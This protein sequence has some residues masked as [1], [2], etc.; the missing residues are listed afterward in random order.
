M[1]VRRTAVFLLVLTAACLR[2]QTGQFTWQSETPLLD[3]SCTAAASGRI[4]FGTAGGL[5]IFDPRD[6]SFSE[7]TNTDGLSGSDV[8][9]LAPSQ[10]GVRAGYDNGMIDRISPAG[11]V[12]DRIGDFAGYR[13]NRIAVTGDSLWVAHD[14]GISLYILSKSE[15]KETYRQLGPS[16]NRDQPVVDILISGGVIWAATAEGLCRAPLSSINLLDPGAWTR[17]TTADGLPGNAVRTLAMHSGVLYAATSGGV[18]RYDSAFTTVLNAGIEALLSDSDG[19]YAGGAGCLYRSVQGGSFAAVPGCSGHITAL[20][21][22]TGTLYAGTTSGILILAGS[23]FSSLQPDCIGGTLI[24][25][26]SPDPENG[27]WVTT[28]DNGFYLYRNGSWSAFR[29]A[30]LAG[31]RSR[32]QYTAFTDSRNRTWIGSWGGG[33]TQI[34]GDGSISFFHPDSGYLSGI[35]NDA[36][37][38]VISD[39]AEDGTGTVWFLNYYAAS[40]RPLA[41]VTPEGTWVYF[42]QNEGLTSP[43]VSAL[44]IDEFGR[45]YIGTRTSGL[46]IFDDSGTPEDKSDD[47]PVDRLT[48]SSGLLSDEITDLAV[49]P[50]GTVW[51]GTPLGLNYLYGGQVQQVYGLPSTAVTALVI[52]PA[53]NIWAGSRNGLNLFTASE[54]RWNL[55]TKSDSYLLDDEI[56]ALSMDYAA[57][58]LY[59]G[60]NRGISLLKT[61]YTLPAE[62]PEQLKTYPNPFRPDEDDALLIDGLTEGVSVDIMTAGGYLVR[63]FEKETVYGRQ[64]WW[65]GRTSRGAPAA[66]GVYVIV[67]VNENGSI[68]RGKCVLIR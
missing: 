4:W 60:T 7:I 28:R 54:Y 16:M 46:F 6:D 56:T 5:L 12:S 22:E 15:V 27:L 67:A 40:A 23:V 2:G 10:D 18:C 49:G 41:A 32:D 11:S 47:L 63:R 24:S 43:F 45:K 62:R 58:I 1:K 44:V 53:N 26:F 33:L 52:D 20:T 31:L 50:D 19:I 25:G 29:P 3:V 21:L 55:Y 68:Q 34:A 61:P 14:I 35:P 66:A 42:G 48:T 51:I 64:L 36:S 59:I 8:T 13:I 65:D 57:G 9:A 38:S 37:Y 17:F 30:T 39:I